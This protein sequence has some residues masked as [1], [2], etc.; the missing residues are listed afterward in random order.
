MYKKKIG[1][2][3]YYYLRASKRLNNKQVTKDIAYLGSTIEEARKNLPLIVKNKQE[4]KKSYRKIKLLL[5]TEYY[6]NKIKKLKLKKDNFL[7][8]NLENIEASKLHY[9]KVFQ[10][11]N[12]KSREEILEDFVIEF[13]YNT[14]SLEGNTITLEEAKNFFETGRTPKDRTLREIYDLQNTKNTLFWLL[15]QKKNLSNNLIIEIHK[16]LME[17]VDERIGYRTKDIRV[18][19]SHFE[20]S[21]GIYVKTDMDLLLKW[22]NENKK[23][24]HPFVLATIFHHK[25]EKV[26]P[27]SDGNGR[28]GRLMITLYLVEKGILKKPILYLSD[29]FEKNRDLYYL[30]LTKVRKQNDIDQWFKFFLVGVIETAKSSINTFDKILKLQKEV[31][32]KLQKLGSRTNNARTIIAYL[33]QRP[34]INANKVKEVTGISMPSAYKLIAALENLDILK[35]ITGGQRRKQYW[36][37]DY[38]NIFK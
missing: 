27:F 4:I 24:L 18:F 33:Y 14:T 23:K 37:Y 32:E 28:V 30:N 31:D 29:F 7:N 15:A 26:H 1:S 19:K 8:D 22:Y 5:E 35:E 25:F 13:A 36:F 9:N 38:I 16:R 3:N 2:R 12:Q 11:L 34:L 6:N 17:N 20:A 21:S 10:K